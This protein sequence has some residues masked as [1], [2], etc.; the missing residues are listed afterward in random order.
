M[1]SA[2]Y[3]IDTLELIRPDQLNDKERRAY[4]AMLERLRGVLDEFLADCA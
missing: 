3:L 4:F 1:R 2:Q